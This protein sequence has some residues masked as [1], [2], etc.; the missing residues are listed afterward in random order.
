MLF[1][2]IA[3]TTEPNHVFGGIHMTALWAYCLCFK[4]IDCIGSANYQ[5]AA[6]VF[7]GIVRCGG[8]PLCILIEWS[9]VRI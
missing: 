5:I 8:K 9:I 4:C 1:E 3:R 6:I 7:S 2:L